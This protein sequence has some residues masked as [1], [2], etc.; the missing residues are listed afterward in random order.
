MKVSP[1]SLAHIIQ[2]MRPLSAKVKEHSERL[3]NDP[4]VKDLA[5]RVRWDW[6]YAA[7]LNSFICALYAKEDV[8]DSHVDTALRHAVTEL[9]FP[10]FA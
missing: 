4:G 1:K 10:E 9:G 2:A 3:R 5:M 8:N 7:G 6:C